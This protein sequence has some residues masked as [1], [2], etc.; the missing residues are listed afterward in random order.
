VAL[1]LDPTNAEVR[2]EFDNSLRLMGNDS[3]AEEHLLEAIAL[4][5][6]R[7]MT[8]LHLAWIDA[9]ATRNTEA[10]RWFDSAIVVLPGFFKGYAERAAMR[11]V[12]GD[13]A[14][15]RADAETAVR[16]RPAEDR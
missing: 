16:L 10:R 7:P 15:A 2:H 4:E 13:T 1:A 9:A 3:A 8:L 5:P 6:D 14:G 12:V 11:R